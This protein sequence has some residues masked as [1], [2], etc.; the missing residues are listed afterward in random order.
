MGGG[1][2]RRFDVEL[3]IVHPSL[4]PSQITA[5]LGLNP[6]VVRKSDDVRW[7]Y[8][9]RY[10]VPDQWFAAKVTEFVDRLV[11]HKEYLRQ[12]RLTG[13]TVSLI[14]QFLGDGYFGDELP[15]AT[16]AKLVDL[17]LDLAIECFLVPQ[18]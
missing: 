15:R 17:E 6:K 11:P 13:G 16:L 18:S 9:V 8:S 12:I 2:L 3:F 14:V 10:E 4:D 7:R 1:D 5:A